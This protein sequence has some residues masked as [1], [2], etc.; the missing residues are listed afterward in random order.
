MRWNELG[1]SGVNAYDVFLICWLKSCMG[2]TGIYGVARCLAL[3]E[4]LLRA[5]NVGP[6]CFS[7]CNETCCQLPVTRNPKTIHTNRTGI[8]R[9]LKPASKLHPPPIV[10]AMNILAP[11]SLQSAVRCCTKATTREDWK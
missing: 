3:Y 8:M 4:N 10:K 7:A 9:M 11:N 1:Q 6:Q 2:T 5:R